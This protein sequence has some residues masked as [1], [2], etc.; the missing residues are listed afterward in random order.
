MVSFR[1]KYV[2]NYLS[3]YVIMPEVLTLGVPDKDGKCVL[4]AP[5]KDTTDIGGRMFYKKLNFK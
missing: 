2:F 4:I 5:D 1:W 3:G